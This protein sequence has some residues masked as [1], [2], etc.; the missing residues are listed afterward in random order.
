MQDAGGTVRF[1]GEGLQG[2]E[3]R[4]STVSEVD[5]DAPADAAAAA[6]QQQQQGREPLHQPEVQPGELQYMQ[7]G[8][9]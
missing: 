6:Q 9:V 7:Q 5:Q 2:I 4:D 8:Q 1:G 3:Q